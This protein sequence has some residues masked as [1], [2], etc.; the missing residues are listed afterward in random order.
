LKRVLKFTV[1]YLVFSL[2]AA[3]ALLIDSWPRHPRSILQWI[4]LFV[5]ALPVTALGEW[6][7]DSVLRS[8]PSLAVEARTR[9]S[10]FS[11]LRIAYLVA[12]Y[13]LFAICVVAIFYWL[14]S[15]AV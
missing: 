7:S 4:L 6:L 15:L 12:L 8:P 9:G 3:M 14:Q 2:F 10:Q 11:W 13:I 1:I 5:I